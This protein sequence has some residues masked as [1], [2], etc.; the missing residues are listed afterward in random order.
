MELIVGLVF[1]VSGAAMLRHSMLRLKLA[2][3]IEDI[4]TS[5]IDSAHQGLVE[6]RGR[7]VLNGQTPLMV[8]RL[9]IPCVWYRYQVFREHGHQEYDS[10]EQDNE[11]NRPVYVEDTTG[12][13]AVHVHLAD[14]HPKKHEQHVIT[15]ATHRMQW[16]GVGETIYALGWLNTLHPA[17]RVGDVIAKETTDKPE[18]RYGQLKQPLATLTEH[19]LG[20]YPFLIGADFEHKIIKKFRTSAFI[21]LSGAFGAAVFGSMMIVA[22]SVAN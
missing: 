1:I 21:W 9:N 12:I 4:P 22:S 18:M 17:P 14:I 6:I 5:R 15:G 3:T 16:I 20:Q 8:P 10:V 19:P 11:S 2:R 7:A 13:C